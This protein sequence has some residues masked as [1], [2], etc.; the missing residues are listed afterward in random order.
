MEAIKP[1]GVLLMAFGGPHSLEAVEPFMTNI[2]GGRK[3][4]EELVSKV[5][6]RYKLIGGKSPL[7]EIIQ[8]QAKAVETLLRD[9]GGNYRVLVGMS[10][11]YPFIKDSLRQMATEGIEQVVAVS[12]SPHYSRVSTGA[13]A[14][15]IEQELSQMQ[16]KLQVKMAGAWYDHPLFIEG[17]AERVNEAFSSF[18]PDIRGEVQVIFSAHSLPVSHIQDGDPYVEQLQAT[19]K[20]LLEKLVIKDWH[21]AYQSKGGGQGDWLG[22]EV[23]EVLDNLAAQG[24][25]N[26]LLV[27]VGFTCDHIE[28][29][30][31]IDIAIRQHALSKNLNFAR[32]MALNTSP[33]FMQALADIARS[34]F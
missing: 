33:K 11:W 16:D 20:A 19:I 17:L 23:E 12:L 22:P 31:D 21:L 10:N 32:A 13:Y 30:Y 34:E 8:S 9:A 5:L 26:I 4:P 29:L 3:P 7:P 2:M 27:P 25:Q 6:E 18:S 14:R 1:K 15:A 28:T 24:K